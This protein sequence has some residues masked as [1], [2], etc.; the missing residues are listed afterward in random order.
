[1]GAEASVIRGQ[2]GKEAHSGGR[3]EGVGRVGCELKARAVPDG[4]QNRET[5]AAREMIQ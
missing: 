4:E 1:M 3:E 2:K 5:R